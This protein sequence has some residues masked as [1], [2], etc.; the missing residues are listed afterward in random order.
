LSKIE[1]DSDKVRWR[2][3]LTYRRLRNRHVRGEWFDVRDLADGSWCSFL[4]AVWSG[5][6]DDAYDFELAVGGYGVVMVRQPETPARHFKI[7]CSCGKLIDG[8]PKVALPTVLKN[9]AT[10]H[11]RLD[12]LDPLVAEWRVPAHH[13]GYSLLSE[14]RRSHLGR[15][16]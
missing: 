8:G 9:Y 10:A 6:L 16:K 4:D 12:A 15:V 3:W 7:E 11:L 13:Q 14:S 2:E 5:T 1:V